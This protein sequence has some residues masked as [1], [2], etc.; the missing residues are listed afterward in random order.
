[1]RTRDKSNME[2]S[3][4]INKYNISYTFPNWN[5]VKEHEC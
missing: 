1:M 3:S 2:E 5:D 4:Y